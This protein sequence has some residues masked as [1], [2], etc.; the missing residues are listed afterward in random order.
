MLPDANVRR[1]FGLLREVCE[2]A[3]LEHNFETQAQLEEA[4][5]KAR[6]K[7]LEYMTLAE[8]DFDPDKAVADRVSSLCKSNAHYIACVFFH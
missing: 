2:F 8:C 3:L 6:Q 7:F 4:V 1:A 5:D